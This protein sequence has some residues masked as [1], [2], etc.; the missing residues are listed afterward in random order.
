MNN[1]CDFKYLQ[2]SKLVYYENIIL[3]FF[4]LLV[5]ISCTDDSSQ[6]MS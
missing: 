6:V 3:R 2:K 4:L 5:R 1:R